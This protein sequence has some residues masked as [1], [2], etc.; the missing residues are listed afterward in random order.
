M[1]DTWNLTFAV[2]WSLL[3]SG[4]DVYNLWNESTTYRPFG[5]SVSYAP[6]LHEKG[7]PLATNIANLTPN[8]K[9]GIYSGDGSPWAAEVLWSGQAF[10]MLWGFWT[11]MESEIS[12]V[13]FLRAVE[14]QWNGTPTLTV[15]GKLSWGA[16]PLATSTSN[17]GAP[18]G[19][20]VNPLGGTDLEVT[21]TGWKDT[22]NAAGNGVSAFV[23]ANSSATYYSAATTDYGGYSVQVSTG[24]GGTA[25]FPSSA[26]PKSFVVTFPVTNTEQFA[27]LNL[28]LVQNES[29]SKAPDTIYAIASTPHYKVDLANGQ[30]LER[31]VS[32]RRGKPEHFLHLS[33]LARLLEGL[34]MDPRPAKQHDPLP[35]AHR[36]FPLHRRAGLRPARAQRYGAPG[37]QRKQDCHQWRLRTSVELEVYF[38]TSS[39]DSTT[40]SSPG[41]CSS[42]ALWV[43]P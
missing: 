43:R 29:T 28:S 36:A 9:D 18:D 38:H 5:S 39:R 25:N 15:W 12:G 37:N 4:W 23:A 10:Q 40:C 26:S 34:D 16:N 30:V 19:A 35:L 42:P 2:S 32:E 1:L 33:G 17:D 22:A 7:Y 27:Y 14:G 6:G 24:S 11:Q 8:P 41:P 13:D 31:V 21:L 3:N 20:Q